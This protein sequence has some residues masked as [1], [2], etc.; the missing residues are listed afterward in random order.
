[1]VHMDVFVPLSLRWLMVPTL[2]Q[3][4]PNRFSYWLYIFGRLA[5]GVTLE[6]ADAQLNSLYGGILNDVEAPMLIEGQAPP[7]AVDQF[8]ERRITFSPG[9]LGQGP[10]RERAAR[11][12]EL[13]LG[14]SARVLLI[15]C[16]SIA[17]LLLERGASRTGESGMPASPGTRRCGR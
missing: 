4:N 8:R 11:P 10:L 6:Q 5:Q 12:L 1:G 14:V 13:L 2:G 17:N 15:V 7:G 16:V 9:E 3:Y